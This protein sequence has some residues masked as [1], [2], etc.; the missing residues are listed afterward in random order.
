MIQKGFFGGSG[1][2]CIIF[3]SNNE[4]IKDLFAFPNEM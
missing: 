2:I 1:L 4:G 3:Q